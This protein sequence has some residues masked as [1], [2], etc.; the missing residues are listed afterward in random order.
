MGVKADFWDK[1]ARLNFNLFHYTVNDQQLTAVGGAANFNQLINAKQ[2]V[3][4]GFEFDFDAYLT[5]NLLVTFGASL[6][7]TEIQDSEP[8]DPALRRRL[9]RAR[10]GLSGQARYR[11]PLTEIGFRRRP[12]GSTT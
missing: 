6:N 10:S 11:C 12:S 5:D 2:T 3:G 1:R 8:V 7:D 9:H 4:K